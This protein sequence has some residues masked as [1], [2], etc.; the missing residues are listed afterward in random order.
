M[1]WHKAQHELFQVVFPVQH[2][3]LDT[4]TPMADYIIIFYG[5][6][7]LCFVGKT[8]YTSWPT[9]SLVSKMSE[10]DDVINEEIVRLNVKISKIKQNINSLLLNRDNIGSKEDKSKLNQDLKGLYLELTIQENILKAA[11]NP[12]YLVSCTS[13]SFICFRGSLE[14]LL[15]NL[16]YYLLGF[17][18]VIP[19]PK[20]SQC[21]KPLQY[22]CWP[23]FW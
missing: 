22:L 23:C 12:N 7:E 13:S 11:S 19:F 16:L 5:L 18:S 17:L 4:S 9:F 8:M 14:S 2:S 15:Y 3:Y 1:N 10:I 21:I 6:W 20:H